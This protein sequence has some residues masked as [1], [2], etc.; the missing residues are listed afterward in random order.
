M[1]LST[2][3]DEL[4]AKGVAKAEVTFDSKG[5]VKGLVVEF[6]PEP[7]PVTPFVDK[8]G[9]PIDFDEDLPPLAHDPI[10]DKNYRK[11]GTD[12]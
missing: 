3:L 11:P 8:D 2:V 1:R 10:A 12:A 5:D 6:A 9:K 7:V 4:K